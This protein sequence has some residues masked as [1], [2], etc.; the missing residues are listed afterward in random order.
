[1]PEWPGAPVP[2]LQ[3]RR[4]HCP[5]RRRPLQVWL[6]ILL[7]I[8]RMVMT[9]IYKLASNAMKKKKS[10]WAYFGSLAEV[11][12]FLHPGYPG[13]HP[14]TCHGPAA[15]PLQDARPDTPAT[16]LPR[17]YQVLYHTLLFRIYHTEPSLTL[18]YLPR[19]YQA[20]LHHNLPPPPLHYAD[21]I[22]NK[23]SL[24]TLNSCKDSNQSSKM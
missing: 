23:Q 17:D 5:P 21:T 16:R 2:G 7:L 20:S 4:H 13:H 3:Y 12:P 8:P 18:P 10:D 6:C 15:D 11:H 1:M 14:Q 19:Y 9:V 22:L 24:L